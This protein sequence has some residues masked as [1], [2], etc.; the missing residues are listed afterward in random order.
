MYAGTYQDAQEDPNI[1]HGNYLQKHQELSIIG[2][3]KVAELGNAIYREK[4]ESINEDLEITS[5]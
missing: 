1:F 3:N 4:L 5:H 2:K